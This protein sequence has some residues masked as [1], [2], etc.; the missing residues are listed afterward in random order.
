MISVERFEAQH[1]IDL[2]LQA[3]QLAE[4]GWHDRKALAATYADAGNAFTIKDKNGRPIFCGGAFEQ[5][6]QYARLWAM[7]AE[8]IS[9]GDYG[10]ILQRTR[11]FIAGLPHRRLDALLADGNPALVRWA[12]GCGLFYETRLG[13]ASP[14]GTDVLIFR[15]ID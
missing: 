4:L 13:A 8:G 7:F 12:E 2:Q 3:S 10:R 1:A 5:H 6:V 14:D 11:A 15:R 9:R